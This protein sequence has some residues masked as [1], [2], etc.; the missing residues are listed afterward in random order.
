VNQ[1]RIIL[2]VCFQSLNI[3]TD[4]TG[5]DFKKVAN[6]VFLKLAEQFDSSI[7]FLKSEDEYTGT[8]KT[9]SQNEEQSK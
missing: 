1:V 6:S 9:E 7:G 3:Y 2:K 5:Y 8:I 4:L